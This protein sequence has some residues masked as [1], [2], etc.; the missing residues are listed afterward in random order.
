MKK[1]ILKLLLLVSLVLVIALSFAGC[2]AI[3][4][5]NEDKVESNAPNNANT[6]H[7]HSF[8]DWVEVKPATCKENGQNV[9]V[10]ECG[11]RETQPT[12]KRDHTFANKKCSVCGIAECSVKQ[13]YFDYSKVPAYS[14][15]EYVKINENVP[16]FKD[17]EKVTDSYETYGAFDSLGRCTAAVACIGRDIMPD[18]P[19]G[20]NPSFQ[21]TGWVQAQYSFVSGKNL[22]NRCHLI[23]WQLTAETTNR[24]NL[25]TGTRYMNEAMIPFEDMIAA[26]IKE[27]NNHVMF[28]ATPIFVGNN[29]LASGLLV[30]AYS[31]EDNGDGICFNVFFYNVQPGVNIDYT[32]GASQATNGNATAAVPEYD[33]VLS[34]LNDKIH[35]TDCS[36]I[37]EISE[38]N[39][40][41]YMGSIEDLKAD[42][43]TPTGNRRI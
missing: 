23:A 7:V 1:G 41:C 37:S 42:D 13:E 25:M 11:K 28:R 32:T 27:T 43:Y 38:V 24:N 15:N 17:N 39:I 14:G 40:V 21:P 33:Y 19:R 10:C 26:Y 12:D 5:E 29:K 30:E 18:G 3:G 6:E 35:T 20:S 34:I 31:V 2:D 22:Y 9:R 8:C 36:N 4:G 16:F